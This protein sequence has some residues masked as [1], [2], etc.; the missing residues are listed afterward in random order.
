MPNDN[1]EHHRMMNIAAA[2]ASARWDWG[3]M[4]HHDRI[5]VEI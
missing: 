5:E 3:A 1:I 2:D 4:G